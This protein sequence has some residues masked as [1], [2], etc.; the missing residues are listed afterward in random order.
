MSKVLDGLHTAIIYGMHF[1][2]GNTE[3]SHSIHGFELYLHGSLIA[4]KSG[5]KYTFTDA[6]YPTRTTLSR[7]NV[8]LQLIHPHLIARVKKGET[9]FTF[10]EIFMGKHKLELDL[11]IGNIGKHL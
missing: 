8:V 6:G 3:L 9:I 5:N 10:K 7:L 4:K 2:M 1:K 11:D